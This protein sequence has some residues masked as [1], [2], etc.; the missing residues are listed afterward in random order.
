MSQGLAMAT[1]FG[2]FV[3]KSMRTLP[4]GHDQSIV[5]STPNFCHASNICALLSP[6]SFVDFGETLLFSLQLL[7]LQ[8]L[9]PFPP[10]RSRIRSSSSC[11]NK[12]KNW[13]PWRWKR[14]GWRRCKCTTKKPTSTL[15]M[16]W[17]LK[18]HLCLQLL[19][20][21]TPGTGSCHR[22]K[23]LQVDRTR[24]P[25]Y[26][27]SKAQ[28]ASRQNQYCHMLSWEPPMQHKVLSPL[29]IDT[30]WTTKKLHESIRNDQ[31]AKDWESQRFRNTLYVPE[32][33]EHWA[34]WMR[35]ARHHSS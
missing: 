6:T 4:C 24:P 7:Q 9:H 33:K 15:M 20:D 25:A 17:K 22:C 26:G 34:H 35:S 8:L 14:T 12:W 32:Q 28:V 31:E 18:Q 19:L 23:G 13:C 11:A 2:C 3:P 29:H 16:G 5:S 21:L 27:T 10:P 30:K 1:T